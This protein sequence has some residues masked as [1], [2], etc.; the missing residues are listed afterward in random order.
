MPNPDG[1]YFVISQYGSQIN[2]SIFSSP[3]SSYPENCQRRSLYALLYAQTW[4]HSWHVFT[5]AGGH[6]VSTCRALRSRSRRLWGRGRCRCRLRSRDEGAESLRPRGVPGRGTCQRNGRT[7]NHST[8]HPGSHWCHTHNG[9]SRGSRSNL[10]SSHGSPSSRGK[11]DSKSSILLG[12]RGRKPH[13][14]S[15]ERQL[16][17]MLGI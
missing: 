5:L 11:R 7:P 16:R 4:V 9:A 15:E 13:V 2:I 10:P 12:K 3:I 6:S 1:W 17:R 8:E 14:R